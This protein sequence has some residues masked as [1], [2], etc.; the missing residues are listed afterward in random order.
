MI[1]F[2]TQIKKEIINMK[3]V[4]IYCINGQHTAQITESPKETIDQFHFLAEH[5]HINPEETFSHKVFS[6]N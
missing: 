3:L 6:L 1:N 2:E 4:N 5:K